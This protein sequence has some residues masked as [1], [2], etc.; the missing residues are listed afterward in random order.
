MEKR[1]LAQACAD[2]MFENDRASQHLGMT[3]RMIE[4]GV[5]E[6]RMTVTENMLNGF[7][8]CHGGFLFSLADSAFAFACNS[9]DDVTVAAGGSIDFLRP[10]KLGDT[11]VATA[12]ESHRGRRSGIYDIQVCNQDDR[13]VAVFR[14]RSAALGTPILSD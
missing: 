7:D 2:R 10:A 1:E 9:Y 11:L 3:I 4:P 6:A 13:L 12:R 5:A 8:V 14:G